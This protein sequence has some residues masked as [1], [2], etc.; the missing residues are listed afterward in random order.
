MMKTT[1]VGIIKVDDV[2]KLFFGPL[3][4]PLHLCDNISAKTWHLDISYSAV[5]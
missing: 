2:Q 5:Q 1:L 3:V 4:L